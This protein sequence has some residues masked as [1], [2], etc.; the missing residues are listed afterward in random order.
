MSEIPPAR[1]SASRPSKAPAPNVTVKGFYLSAL[2]REL[3]S[4]GHHLTSRSSFRDFAD[5][6]LAQAKE[7]LDETAQRL[8][9]HERKGEAMRRV[10]WIIYPT[11]LGTMVGRVI[12][13]SLGD[14]LQA[15]LRVAGRGFEVSISRGRYELVAVGKNHAHVRVREFPLY[16]ETFLLGVFEGALARY[17]Y[18]DAKVFARKLSLTDVDLHLE[19]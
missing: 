14:D 9:P 5:Y 6:P 19:W 7:M 18:A 12:F 15:V 4:H 2:V 17:G 13:G 8:Y 11:L 16:P 10:G 1:E 3:A